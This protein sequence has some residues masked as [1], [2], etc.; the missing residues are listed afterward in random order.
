MRIKRALS[1]LLL[2]LLILLISACSGHTDCEDNDADGICDTCGETLLAE[3]EDGVILVK[4]GIAHFQVV[5]AKDISSE[6]FG[7]VN[8]A[9]RGIL[10]NKHDIVV[11][12]VTEGSDRDKVI[13]TEILIGEVKS[14]GE[15]Y[16]DA[17]YSLCEDDYVIKTVGTKI[18]INAGSAEKL[19]SAVKEFSDTVLERGTSEITAMRKADTVI[20][21]K[22][23]YSVTSVKLNGA[24]MKDYTIATDLSSEI[25][26]SGAELLQKLFF[27]KTGYW[28][29][30][31]DIS[32]ADDKAIIIR[33]ASAPDDESS[34]KIH[35]DGSKLL[36]ECA[37]DSALELGIKSFVKSVIEKAENELNFNNTVYTRDITV[38]YYEDFGAV[39]DGK[40]NDFKAMYDTHVHA[41]E[42]GQTVKG[43]P[44]AIYYIKDTTLPSSYN[45]GVTAI[46]IRTNTDWQGA[47]IIIDDSEIA[48]FSGG[49]NYSLSSKHI[50]SILPD[51]EHVG[52]KFTDEN[53]IKAILAD[54]LNP[55]TERINLK[56][57]GWDGPLMI[58]PYNNG[59]KI[60]RRRGYAQ[61][62]G[63]P[64][65]EVIVIE[66]DGSISEETPVMFEYTNIDYITV[67][68]LDPDS[69]ISVGNATIE[70]IDTRI[71]HNLPTASGAY[72]YTTGYRKRGISVTRSY[73]TVHN[74]T[75][76]VSG[77]F[78][79]N[80]RSAGL[81]GAAA[82]GMFTAQYANHVTFKDCVI[83][84]RQSY[85]EDGTYLGHSSYNFNAVCV[86][87]ILL[88]H[89]IQSNFWV[90]VNTFMGTMTP[91]AEYVDGAI[92]S[93]S[94]VRI[95]GESMRMHWGIGGTN[96][97]K[98][99]EYVD[100]KISRFD[101]HAGLYNGKIVNTEINMISITGY[102]EMILENVDWYQHS[103]TN[104]L[105]Y[106][107][108]DY[109]YHWNGDVKIKDT[110]AHLYDFSATKPVF[111]LAMHRYENW[112]W[113]YS[114]AFPN[115]TVDN[116]D[117]YGTKSQSPVES[118]FVANLFYFRSNAKGMHLSDSTSS[119]T[120]YAITDADGDGYIDE[121]LYD[122]NLDGKI[123]E[124]DRIDVDGDGK[125]GNT[126][127]KMSSYSHWSESAKRN[128]ATHPSSKTNV[129]VIKPPQYVKII[130]N[131]GVDGKGG[132]V[133]K[134]VNT[135][136]QGISDGGWHRD[137]SAPDT[138]GGFFG[139]TKF[140][141]D[142]NGQ[143]YIL[144]GSNHPEHSITF[145]FIE[146][147]LK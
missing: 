73:T 82:N 96:Y 140:I 87:K 7:T 98:N 32:E 109:G 37:Y 15:E 105:I 49:L 129:N 5:L 43:T 114:T 78:D 135:A 77:G 22:K 84:G 90:K 126:R 18:L 31:T 3:D 139:G 94:V 23:D 56:I 8:S 131:D 9:I 134:I 103:T 24:D 127:L 38:L 81:A 39:G 118:G 128:G 75:H 117:I 112:Y 79:L 14:R 88:E 55:D 53:A 4:N 11:E 25:Y 47:K 1:A 83:P 70:T 45:T 119:S 54:G 69:A 26:S 51:T 44:G 13:P 125:I 136:N 89:C 65:H 21:I 137:A 41:N 48:S 28:L 66:E 123:N 92:P 122:S 29:K 86:N 36:V 17:G 33:H 93:M 99:M 6:L 16:L 71:N 102:G 85:G 146:N 147:Y 130:N 95:N 12:I 67:Y 40:T 107:R 34:F 115:F 101:A 20:S 10:R 145:K 58:I 106:F 50:F 35:V 144:N 91:S 27:S 19:K 30:V 120:V 124:A 133:F 61:Y 113:G 80:E 141:Y 108:D 74:V 60:F 132:Y 116:L 72:K 142:I 62:A 76:V 121:P 42:S 110:R 111:Y 57:D 97:C 52:F 68:K 143:Q 63:E 64:M 59:H 100:S 104:P 2:I 46:P 138:M